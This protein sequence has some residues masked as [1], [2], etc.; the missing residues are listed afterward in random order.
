MWSYVRQFK[1]VIITTFVKIAHFVTNPVE[2]SL[3]YK[4]KQTTLQD[5]SKWPPPEAIVFLRMIK[6]KGRDDAIPEQ[7]KRPEQ[8]L[9]SGQRISPG[10]RA[11]RR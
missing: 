7:E 3:H 8:E 5:G 4:L 2:Q 9:G 1:G 11:P 6:M 10:S